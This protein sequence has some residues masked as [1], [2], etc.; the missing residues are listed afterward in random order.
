MSRINFGNGDLYE[1]VTVNG[2][3]EGH[4]FFVNAENDEWVFGRF[5]DDECVEV[6]DGG[7]GIPQEDIGK[8]F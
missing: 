5:E 2:K 8:L 4:G 6:I 1:G 7:S 3:M